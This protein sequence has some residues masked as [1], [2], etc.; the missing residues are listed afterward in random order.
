MHAIAP[1]P[2]P[3]IILVRGVSVASFPVPMSRLMRSNAKKLMPEYGNLCKTLVPFPCH[4]KTKTH[5]KSVSHT[6][7]RH[8]HIAS[9]WMFTFQNARSPSSLCTFANALPSE[10]AYAAPCDCTAGSMRAEERRVGKEWVRTG[11]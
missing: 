1:A 4:T 9:A 10:G 7:R 6:R 2:A 3:L 5:Q 11:K 8:I